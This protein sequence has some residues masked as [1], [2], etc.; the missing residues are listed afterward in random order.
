MYDMLT[1]RRRI[2]MTKKSGEAPSTDMILLINSPNTGDFSVNTNYGAFT[3]AKVSEYPYLGTTVTHK[4]SISNVTFSL[5][6]PLSN[7]FT[8]LEFIVGVES[9]GSSNTY[10]NTSALF[11]EC[12][13]LRGIPDSWAGLGAVTDASYMFDFCTSLTSIP[14]SWEG[15]GALTDAS[16]MFAFCI[17]LTSIPSSWEGLGALTD[18]S[19]MFAE[20]PSLTSIP[21]SWEGLGA[22]TDASY[23]FAFCTS[24]TNCGTIFTGLAK[25][26]D[27]RQLFDGCTGM[28]GDI[29][30][31][32]V[33]LSTKPIAV[34]YNSYCFRNCTQAVGYDLIPS[35]WK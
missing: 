30:A 35:S 6:Q 21:S 14:S 7:D 1:A 25:V 32:Y 11:Q 24:L 12:T 10:T 4:L 33:Y 18:A 13:S 15:L 17:S 34:S 19:C 29:H 23:M 3:A 28:L 8:V 27:V 9:W 26:T 2:M 16:Y 31:L 5:G 20:C 22:L